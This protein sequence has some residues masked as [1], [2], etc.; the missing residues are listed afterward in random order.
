MDCIRSVEGTKTHIPSAAIPP[1]PGLA[2]CKRGA[3]CKGGATAKVWHLRKLPERMFCSL[4]FQDL[5]FKLIYSIY[6]WF[7]P[8]WK[9]LVKLGI[10]SPN[11]GEHNKYLKPPPRYVY[12]YMRVVL[13]S[14]IWKTSSSPKKKISFAELS[15]TPCFSFAVHVGEDF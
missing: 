3:A 14:F 4:K 9:I 1:N 6:W 7:Q 11:R 12:I 5:G 8:N 13:N 15:R 2:H 10:I